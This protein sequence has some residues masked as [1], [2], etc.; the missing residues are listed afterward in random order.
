MGKSTIYRQL[1]LYI[2]LPVCFGF[3]LLTTYSIFQTRNFLKKA[4][5]Q[6]NNRLISEIKHLMEFQDLALTV[7]EE[8]LDKKMKN[9]SNIIINQYLRNTKEAATIDLNEVRKKIFMDPELEDIY[10]ID[11][12]GLI[13][14]TTFEQDKLLNFFSFGEHHKQYLKSI[15]Q[16]GNFVSERFTI[17]ARTKRLR[18]YTYQPTLDRKYIVELGIYSKKLMK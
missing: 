8:L 7:H 16:N 3:I 1:L 5:R 15:F 13:I 12:T 11:S 6:E 18:K 10:I 17:E 14:N 4:N 9:F 2:L